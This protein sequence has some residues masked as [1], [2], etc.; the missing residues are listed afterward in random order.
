MK[1]TLI[2]FTSLF[3]CGNLFAQYQVA[4]QK[5]ASNYYMN[6]VFAGDYP[7][8][9]ILRDGKDYYIVHSSF[10]YYPGLLIWHSTDLINWMPV[11]N[12]LHTYVG[13]AWAPDM[14]K[15]N[16]K[17]Y[18]YFPTESKKY[19][20]WAESMNGPWS[21]PI[22]LKADVGIDPDHVVDADGN[23]YLYFSNRGCVPLSDDGLSGFMGL[24]IG[25]CAFVEGTVAF[26]NFRYTPVDAEL[27]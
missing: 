19:V 14:V 2:L 9:S 10:E 7:D 26:K 8:P 6:P 21:D 1:I 23:R 4:S 18:V 25:L 12:I 17:Y 16:G 11:T 27:K 15:Y 20:V 5:E 3:L 24:R 22:D 13:S